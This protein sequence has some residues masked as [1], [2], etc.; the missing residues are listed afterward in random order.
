MKKIKKIAVVFLFFLIVFFVGIYIYVTLP[1]LSVKYGNLTLEFRVNLKE[2]AKIKVYPNASTTYQ[3]LWNPKVRNVTIDFMNTS[4]LGLTA[5][6]AFEITYKLTIGYKTN[7]YVV[8]ISA[9]NVESFENLSA[10][11]ENPIIVLV[12]PS[13]SN[14]TSVKIE[15]NIIYINGIDAKG[16]DLATAKLIMIGLEIS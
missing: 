5:V 3:I 9:K 7:N 15:G 10:T 6:E 4:D 11:E 2:A 13:I 8:G 1:V 12:P 16:F 14:E